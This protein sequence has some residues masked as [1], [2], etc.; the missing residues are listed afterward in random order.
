MY[1]LASDTRRSI[2][3]ISAHCHHTNPTQNSTGESLPSSSANICAQRETAAG[4]VASGVPVLLRV[5]CASAQAE[6]ANNTAPMNAGLA[7]GHTLADE[8]GTLC[9]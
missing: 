4:A 1:P 8:S 9:K 2:S 3:P 7:S 5:Q 6:A